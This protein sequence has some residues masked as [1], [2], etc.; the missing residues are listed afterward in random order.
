[1]SGIPLNPDVSSNQF[2][3]GIF[4]SI[5][6]APAGA[7]GGP[8]PQV[9]V[10]GPAI[11]S[12]AVM[13][14]APY[15]LT[16]GTATA[17][18]ISARYDVGDIA[19][20]YHRRSPLAQALR[21]ALQEVPVGLTIF[22]A[23]APEPTASGFAGVAS[24][25]ITV[26]G[27]AV[28]SG[29][30]R[31]WLCG[32]PFNFI[33]SNGDTA[34]TVA[35]NMKAAIDAQTPDATMLTG[36]LISSVTVSLAFS[37]RSE[38]GNERPVVLSV[39][40]TITGLTFS[41]GKITITGDAVGAA[42]ASSLFTLTCGTQS[43]S[44]AIAVGQTPTQQATTI[45]A[46]I[47]AATFPLRASAALGVVTL[48]HGSGWVVHR[49]TCASTEDGGGSTYTLADRH[50][51]GNPPAISSAATTPGS[52]VATA[53]Q[54]AGVPTLTTLLA[55]RAKGDGVSNVYS[56][57]FSEYSDSTSAAAIYNHVEQYAGGG[58]GAQQ[59]QRVFYADGRALETAK[60][61]VT[62]PSPALTNSWRY[63]VGVSQDMVSRTANASAQLAARVA[64]LALPFNVDGLPLRSGTQPLLPPR[65]ETDLDPSSR[66]VAMRNYYLTCYGGSNG[67]VR[68]V[69]GVTTWGGGGNNDRTWSD[70]SFG[71]L[72]DD[73]RY[74]LRNFLAAR[75]TGRVL[76]DVGVSIRV[77]NGFTTED[78]RTAVIEWLESRD[79]ITINNA[80]FLARLVQVGVDANDPTQ[81]NIAVKLNVPRE[82]H[83][84]A[85]VLSRAS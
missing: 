24:A 71:R 17:N 68:V 19:R 20:A 46:A 8:V 37:V 27:T 57:W 52:A 49:I 31:G 58:L 15:S 56:E 42:A 82:I 74:R 40:N 9:L 60:T 75:F 2:E 51:H 66:D 26:G 3:P 43:L 59:G 35:T 11:L 23:A 39:P 64:A 48:L 38:V 45:A 85:G 12:G 28:G 32:W 18:E 84:I 79:G 73:A 63:A 33:V 83:K 13:T 16:A 72:F 1:M 4:L 62:N 30:V 34:A 55:N 29:V 54:G 6:T 50:D 77:A 41:P 7:T 25:I 76:F 80:K 81:I 61:V 44:V 14:G 78:V 67:Q 53:L 70:F 65:P 36:A 47:N 22:G 10:L 69:R 21:S 5:S